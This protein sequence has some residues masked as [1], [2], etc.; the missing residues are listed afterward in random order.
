MQMSVNAKTVRLLRKKANWS[1]EELAAAS[2]LSV[3]TVQRVET[4]GT[5]ALDTQKALAA[6]F[7]VM[8][9]DLEHSGARY[10]PLE[11]Q[12]GTGVLV[13]WIG[14]A[15]FLDLGLSAGLLGLGAIYL[16]GQAARVVWRKQQPLWEL[17]ALGVTCL[18][19][20]LAPQLGLEIRLGGVILVGIGT[21]LMFSRHKT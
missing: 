18:V 11:F 8:P 3:R 20:G 14:I 5:A 12:V 6:A 17:V 7:G 19:A 2:G 9:S 21:L 15:W 13:T 4:D 1:Q 10:D 16:L